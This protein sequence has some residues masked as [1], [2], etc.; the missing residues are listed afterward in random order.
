MNFTKLKE[1]SISLAFLREIYKIYFLLGDHFYFKIF[2]HSRTYILLMKLFGTLRLAYGESLFGGIR[3]NDLAAS[4]IK[5][6]KIIRAMSHFCGVFRMKTLG[7][8][9]TS[10][11]KDSKE[12]FAEELRDQPLKVVSFVIVIAVIINIALSILLGRKLG[13]IEWLTRIVLL[14]FGWAYFSSFFTWADL[15]ETSRFLKLLNN[16]CKILK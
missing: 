12:K 9:V 15:K 1:A 11:I 2:I 4:L 6:S 13:I 16:C 14:V 3:I 5:N 8:F 7:F 10:K